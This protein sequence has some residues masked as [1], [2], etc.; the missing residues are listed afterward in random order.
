MMKHLKSE[1]PYR[2]ST[3]ESG[4]R[5][6]T[7]V[8]NYSIAAILLVTVDQRIFIYADASLTDF[9]IEVPQKQCTARW[10]LPWARYD[11]GTHTDQS[12]VV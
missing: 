7:R 10:R 6:S 12:R 11:H 8:E 1:H 2:I 3:G 4:T 9:Y 5:T